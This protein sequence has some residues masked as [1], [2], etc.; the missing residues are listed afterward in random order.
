MK[1]LDYTLE[2]RKT[3]IIL[4]LL[5]IIAIFL[6]IIT[7]N[8]SILDSLYENPIA[9]AFYQF[10]IGNNI[11]NALSLGFLVS[12]IFY[13]IV[14]FLPAR[15]KEKDIAP[16]IFEK[17][18]F[19][20]IHSSDLIKELIKNSG[21]DYDFRK[22]TKSQFLEICTNTKPKELNYKF[23][24][25]LTERVDS[26]LGYKLYKDWSELA[27]EIE[28]VLKLLPYI[29][30]GLLKRIY[31]LYKSKLSNSIQDIARIEKFKTNNLSP[32]SESFYDFYL[33][34]RDLR[35]YT[36]F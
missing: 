31:K 21:L 16:I 9:K 3:I 19:L 26:H 28:V 10:P 32:W 33:A 11:I 17:C 7:S 25:N 23:A 20:I 15:Q 24:V 30:S 5:S 12:V 13:M 22:L 27:V 36:L 34:T 1:K 35:D 29:E 2:R 14:V 6:T 4:W 8:D 18:E